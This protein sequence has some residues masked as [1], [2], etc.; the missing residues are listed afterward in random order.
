MTDFSRWKVFAKKLVQLARHKA[1]SSRLA[2]SFSGIAES[3]LSRYAS[4]EGENENRQISLFLWLA[5]DSSTGYHGLKEIAR[6]AG[7]EIISRE[8]KAELAESIPKLVGATA[9][10]DAGFNKA[11]LDAQSDGS[12]NTR[13]LRELR[14]RRMERD[15]TA[16]RVMDAVERLHMVRVG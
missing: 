3:E 15:D 5:L 8:Q 2:S 12:I 4:E 1:G 16:D 11:V 6:E 7:F 14:H 9:V 10:A 13:E